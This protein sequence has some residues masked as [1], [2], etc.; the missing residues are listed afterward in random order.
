M[1][2]TSINLNA[3]WPFW[4]LCM[5]HCHQLSFHTHGDKKKKLRLIRSKLTICKTWCHPARLLFEE[6]LM[7]TEGS[8]FVDNSMGVLNKICVKGFLCVLDGHHRD[9]LWFDLTFYS[10][11]TNKQVNIELVTPTYWWQF[12]RVK[13]LHLFVYSFIRCLLTTN[14]VS[15]DNILGKGITKIK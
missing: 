9:W 8:A 6:K 7:Y 13:C 15:V 14:D 10:L 4:K 1:N 12:E 2:F 5:E 11:L 3:S